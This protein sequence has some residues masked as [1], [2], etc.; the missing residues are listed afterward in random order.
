M[1]SSSPPSSSAAAGGVTVGDKNIDI[2]S[3]SLVDDAY[4]TKMVGFEAGCQEGAGDVSAC[5]HVGE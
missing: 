4:I 2:S 3:L 1:A 5:H